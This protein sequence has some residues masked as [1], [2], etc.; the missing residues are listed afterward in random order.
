M[1][2]YDSKPLGGDGAGLK[3]GAGMPPVKQ[4]TAPNPAAL[5]ATPMPPM[6]MEGQFPQDPM[7]AINPMNADVYQGLKRRRLPTG[8]VV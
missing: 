8:Q 3:A 1:G 2:G 7:A 6:E 4:L 5:V